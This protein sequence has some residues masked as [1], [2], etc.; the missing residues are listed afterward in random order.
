MKHCRVIWQKGNSVLEFHQQPLKKSYD[1]KANK[2]TGIIMF[3][4][5]EGR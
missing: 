1:L 2:K 3:R 5:L 4:K